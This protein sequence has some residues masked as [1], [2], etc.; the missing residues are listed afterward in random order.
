[1]GKSKPMIK[2]PVKAKDSNK[3]FTIIV[4][5]LVLAII[6]VLVIAKA[7][8]STEKR[9]RD[10]NKEAITAQTKKVGAKATDGNYK[11]VKQEVGKKVGVE[12]TGLP[13]LVQGAADP[14][15][16][17]KA[18]VLTMDT[19]AG[20]PVEINP[21]GKAYMISFLAH[22]CEHCN[23][24]MPILKGIE[25]QVPKGLEV[26]GVATGV[27]EAA[28]HYPPSTW[29]ASEGFPYRVFLDDKAGLAMNSM[30]GSGYPHIVF[31]DAAGN[32]T[33]RLT[34]ESPAADLLEAMNQ[35]VGK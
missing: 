15:T 31:I 25:K 10:R 11:I 18:P 13:E 4:G 5:V 1:M 7:T 35:A 20:E 28:A 32:V 22:W 23:A 8:S 9:S 30:G 19:F 14:A 21:V 24:E 26:I 27:N 6:A 33:K 17:M 16:G 2:T 12:G 34:G 3:L 29:F